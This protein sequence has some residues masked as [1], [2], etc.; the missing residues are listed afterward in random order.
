MNNYQLYNYII[1]RLAN[2]FTFQLGYFFSNF[3]L[4]LPYNVSEDT[5]HTRMEILKKSKKDEV[6]QNQYLSESKKQEQKFIIDF[7]YSNAES[8]LLQQLSIEGRLIK[9][10]HKTNTLKIKEIDFC[11]R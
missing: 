3:I 7:I 9:T 1:T 10:I 4:G 6:D 8:V 2:T 5:V 11:L